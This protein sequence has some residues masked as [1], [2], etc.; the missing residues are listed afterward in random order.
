MM[1]ILDNQDSAT[2]EGTDKEILSI[3]E[4]WLLSLPCDIEKRRYGHFL[5]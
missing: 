1:N 4:D 5:Q 3:P 2:G